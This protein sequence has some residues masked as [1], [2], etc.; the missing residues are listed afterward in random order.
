VLCPVL[1]SFG[2]RVRAFFYR[3][4]PASCDQM[5][6]LLQGSMYGSGCEVLV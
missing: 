5:F 4:F 2:A 6:W 1:P 3:G